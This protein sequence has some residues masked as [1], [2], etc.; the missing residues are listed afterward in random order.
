MRKEI[1]MLSLLHNIVED[2]IYNVE[3]IR[4]KLKMNTYNSIDNINPQNS[5]K[6]NLPTESKELYIRTNNT[7]DKR[8]FSIISGYD[9]TVK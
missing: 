2:N 3:D 4:Q 6:Q 9:N 5:F 1:N 7:P 8:Y